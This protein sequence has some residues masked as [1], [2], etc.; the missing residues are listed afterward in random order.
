MQDQNQD[1]KKQPFISSELRPNL[2]NYIEQCPPLMPD[3]SKEEIGRQACEVIGNTR[4]KQLG[5][6]QKWFP[7]DMW[8]VKIARS[9]DVVWTKTDSKESVLLHLDRGN[10]YSLNRTSTYIWE[11]LT[12]SYSLEEILSSLCNKFEVSEN[13]AREDLTH[14]V[15]MLRLKGLVVENP[16]QLTSGTLQKTSE[17]LEET[18][19]TLHC[20]DVK[21]VYQEILLIEHEALVKITNKSGNEYVAK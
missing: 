10:Y 19:L 4:M 16:K 2:R 1:I 15:A 20:S 8:K 7:S 5:L 17:T 21:D 6:T 14:F 18:T 9:S 13:V 12:G 11:L 3:A